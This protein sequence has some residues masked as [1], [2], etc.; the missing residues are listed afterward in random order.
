M[1]ALTGLAGFLAIQ[2]TR[3]LMLIT[4]IVLPA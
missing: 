4:D 2:A 3:V 1:E